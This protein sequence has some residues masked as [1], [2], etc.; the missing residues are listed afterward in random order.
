MPQMKKVVV[1]VGN[2][3][4]YADTY[5]QALAQ[6]GG[7]A[8]SARPAEPAASASGQQPSPATAQPVTTSARAGSD[9]RVEEIAGHLRRYRE[10]V[11]QGRLSEAGKELEAI[12]SIVEKR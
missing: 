7:G 6:I 2:N 9:R 11:S 1:A 3:L 8:P 10:L 4:I 5:A 12:Q